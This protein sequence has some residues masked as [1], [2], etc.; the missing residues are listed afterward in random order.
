MFVQTWAF[1]FVFFFKQT[2]AYAMRISDWSSDVCSSDLSRAMP[3]ALPRHGGTRNGNTIRGEDDAGKSL[4][5]ISAQGCVERKLGR[6][7]ATRRSIS[8][9]Q[10]GRA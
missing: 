5:H 10:I 1:M 2:T 4:L 6:F 8:M 9:P 3:A 7:G